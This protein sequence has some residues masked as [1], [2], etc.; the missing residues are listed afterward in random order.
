MRAVLTIAKY[1][2]IEQLRNR[3]YL[4]IAFF[5]VVMLVSSLLLGALAPGYKI[6]VIFDFG[7]VMLEL[8]GL[9]AAVFGSVTLVLQEMET[10]TIYLLL[11]RPLAR[12]LYIL[13]RFLGLTSAV[14]ITMVGMSVIHTLLMVSDPFNFKDFTMNFNFWTTYPLLVTM[15]V[16]KMVITS[17]LAVFFSLF[18]TSPVSALVFTG[19]FWVAG[20]FTQEMAFMMGR[21]FK[22]PMANV[23]GFISH[24]IPNYQYLNFRDTFMIPHNP[25]MDFL[26]WAFLYAFAYTAFFLILSSIWFSKKE[27]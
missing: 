5:A 20:H 1:T 14:I 19:G 3:L 22:G 9:V 23:V 26:G 13:G 4:I 10:K 24:V 7:L 12:P 27:F 16:L 8:F 11:T 6:R 25:T 21:V 17:A 18:A 2:V 15:S